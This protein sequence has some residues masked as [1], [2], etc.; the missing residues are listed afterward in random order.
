[1]II[2]LVPFH[3]LNMFIFV[4]F[5]V[6]FL[7][8]L[9][10]FVTITLFIWII[11]VA[12]FDYFIDFVIIAL[13]TLSRVF[14]LNIFTDIKFWIFFPIIIS[15]SISILKV[16]TFLQ[17]SV[18]V[19]VNSL[20]TCII[21]IFLLDIWIVVWIRYTRIVHIIAGYRVRISINRRVYCTVVFHFYDASF[22]YTWIRKSV[23]VGIASCWFESHIHYF[24]FHVVE[25]AFELLCI[26]AIEVEPSDRPFIVSKWNEYVEF[27]AHVF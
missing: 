27:V 24:A 15:V 18:I 19:L 26:P 4:K 3:W 16:I 23:S 1:M 21:V 13:L 12:V 20:Y 14:V 5:S 17:I 10:Q 2:P 25:I 11:F 8:I 9:F 7:T 22:Y 6:V